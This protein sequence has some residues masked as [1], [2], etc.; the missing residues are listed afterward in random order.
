MKNK[1]THPCRQLSQPWLWPYSA[2]TVARV[3]KALGRLQSGGLTA[4]ITINQ[5]TFWDQ[6][7]GFQL[8]LRDAAAR[9]ITLSEEAVVNI[10][11]TSAPYGG[12]L[13]GDYCSLYVEQVALSCPSQAATT[14]P[15]DVLVAEEQQL[16]SEAFLLKPREQWPGL[17]SSCR[18]TVHKDVK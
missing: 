5:T 13:R 7:S 16:L 17:L 15:F 4:K 18:R 12:G 10:G 9:S 6:D 1:R 8:C 11:Q 14:N 3:V 2:T